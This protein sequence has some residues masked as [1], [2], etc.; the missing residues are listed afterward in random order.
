MHLQLPKTANYLPAK[1]QRKL[2]QNP[3]MDFLMPVYRK[4]AS[5]MSNNQWSRSWSRPQYR[6]THDLF[7]TNDSIS[8][9][10]SSSQNHLDNFIST[11][12]EDRKSTR[13]NS[14]HVSIS[15][16]VFCLKKKKIIS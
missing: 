8:D 2:P 11:P 16:A 14:S 13:L 6:M 7:K 9:I 1:K 12:A 15:Y 4:W 10:T 5:V 3:H